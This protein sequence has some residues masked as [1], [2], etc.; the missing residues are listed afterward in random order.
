MMHDKTVV[1]LSDIFGVTP[2]LRQLAQDIAPGQ[3][4]VIIDP[5]QGQEMAFA[6]E[7]LAYQYFTE[8]L[9]LANYLTMVKYK[10][11]GLAH[12]TPPGCVLGFSVGGSV[13]WQLAAEQPKLLA[14]ALNIACYASQVRNMRELKPQV[15][16]ELVMPKSEAH[17]NVDALSE[18]LVNRVN[19]KIS[20]T[21]YFHGFA[22]QCS[23]NFD[24]Q[25]YREFCQ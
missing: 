21:D 6:T 3:Q 23:T 13:L 4:C 12:I 1:I 11:T 10:L 2:A 8:Q 18:H 15:P 25:G 24:P 22:N 7:A 16:I 14:P 20:K 5:Y 19:V 9:G 17:F